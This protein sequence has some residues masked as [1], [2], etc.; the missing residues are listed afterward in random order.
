MAQLGSCPVAVDGIGS[1]GCIE[2]PLLKMI[3]KIVLTKQSHQ[4][5][6]LTSF[7]T[8]A[9]WLADLAEETSVYP[10]EMI[11]ELENTSTE[12][13][14]PETSAGTKVFIRDGLYGLMFKM[15][16]TPDQNRLLQEYN[17]KPWRAVL[18]DNDGTMIGTSPDGTVVKGM[19]VNYL[20]VKP[21]ELPLS[22]DGIQYAVV[23]I[24]FKYTAEFN[25]TPRYAI[26]PDL[27]W[28]PL[29][30]VQPLTK[31]TITTGAIAAFA[32]TA[33]FAYVDPTTGQ[34]IPLTS[35]DANGAEL[36]VLDQA[37]AAVTVTVASTGTEGEYTITDTGAGMTSGSIKLD[38]QSDSLYYSDTTT[39]S[40]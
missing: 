4:W 7:Q 29:E 2:A 16:L 36:T 38:A 35:L 9:D 30:I 40:A 6:T 34:S 19:T 15:L 14:A 32:F 23:E 10:L 26:G 5:D 20:R 24:Q 22:A 28:N 39:V 12:E 31:I 8:E 17:N 27:D 11:E 21:M 37:A 3:R 13:I 1:G 33:A 25:K 18:I